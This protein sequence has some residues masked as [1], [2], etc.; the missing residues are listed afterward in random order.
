MLVVSD[1]L[2]VSRGI[3]SSSPGQSLD[4]DR[5]IREAQKRSVAIYVIYAPSTTTLGNQLLT[6]NAQ[7]CLEKSSDDT[8]GRA[9]FQGSAA[10]VSFEP[11]LKEIES[12]LD[13]Q[14]ALTY[15]STHPTKGF[16]RLDI[17]SL[18]RDVAVVHPS[19]YTR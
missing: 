3:D 18:D 11:F 6:G 13:R 16:H 17:K 5:A 4:L 8:G 12:S 9:F 15:L 2:D 7:S 19:G 14:I 10:P 1:G